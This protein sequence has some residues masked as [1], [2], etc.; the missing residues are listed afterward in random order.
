MLERLK[1]FGVAVGV[2]A[3][4]FAGQVGLLFPK[5]WG[6]NMLVMSVAFVYMLFIVSLLI[7]LG[8]K[9]NL[10]GKSFAPIRKH[11]PKI[12]LS[13]G[14]IWLTNLLGVLVLNMEGAATTSNQGAINDLISRLPLPLTF[15]MIVLL[16]PIGEELLCRGVIPRLLFKDYEIFGY[17]A[18]AAFFAFLHHPTNVGSWLIYGGMSAVITTLA[19]KTKSLET[20]MG[21]H[22]MIN[23]IS[24]LLMVLLSPLLH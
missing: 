4:I 8:Q 10:I 24:F 14:C 15:V 16:A 20:S 5:W 1:W 6:N 22:F 18:G 17:I 13:Y 3:L 2:F 7:W 11:L 9:L 23:G 21:L 12:F 19:Y